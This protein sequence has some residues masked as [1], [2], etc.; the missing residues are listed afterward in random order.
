[1]PRMLRSCGQR[2]T[3]GDDAGIGEAVAEG[4]DEDGGGGG[5]FGERCEPG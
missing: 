5:D 4:G 2:E 3:A 1:M